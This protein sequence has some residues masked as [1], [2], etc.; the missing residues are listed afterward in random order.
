[1]CHFTFSRKFF[2]IPVLI[3]AGIW[4][5][6][7][8]SCFMYDLHCFRTWNSSTDRSWGVL[9]SWCWLSSGRVPGRREDPSRQKKFW[10]KKLAEGE[11]V[12]PPGVPR[13]PLQA[14]TIT[15]RRKLS[16]PLY[17]SRPYVSSDSGAEAHGRIGRL[18]GRSMWHQLYTQGRA[19]S[20]LYFDPETMILSKWIRFP[21]N[22]NHLTKWK[23]IWLKWE[24]N[25][26]NK[27]HFKT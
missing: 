5:R 25:V 9:Q 8:N 16:K 14:R 6:S 21:P 2:V 17:P 11:W 15:P 4:S 19:E 24:S 23:S 26:Q 20:I 1:M 3:S 12:N 13:M 7:R 27:I 22:E 10:H 18:V